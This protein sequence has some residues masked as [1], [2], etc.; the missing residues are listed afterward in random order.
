MNK[1]ILIMVLLFS[2]AVTAENV[3]YKRSDKQNM[4]THIR[5]QVMAELLK[6][7]ADRINIHS[8]ETI[9]YLSKA[10]GSFSDKEKGGMN[11][12]D[13]Y[14]NMFFYQKGWAEGVFSTISAADQNSV[15]YGMCEDD[16]LLF[17]PK[18]K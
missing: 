3:K 6:L 8:E 16:Q 9:T 18:A 13:Y 11:N 10:W 14:I 1:L 4:I 12:R 7:S 17:S 5:C 2:T 15:Y